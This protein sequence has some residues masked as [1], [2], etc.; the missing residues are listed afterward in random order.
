MPSQLK[1]NQ[2]NVVRIKNNHLYYFWKAGVYFMSLVKGSQYQ[3]YLQHEGG[4]QG[5]EEKEDQHQK[6]EKL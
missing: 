2:P 4:H 3:N 5:E 6:N 1:S